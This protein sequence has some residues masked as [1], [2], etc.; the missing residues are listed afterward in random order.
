MK[1]LLTAF[2]A[3]LSVGLFS[4]QKEVTDIFN[5]SGSSSGTQLV[6]VISK[7]GSDSSAM[8]FGYNASKKLTDL[9]SFSVTSGTTSSF[10]MRA[11]RNAQGIIQKVII[12]SD[13]YQQY[14]LDSVITVV[15]YQAGHYSTEVTTID[16]GGMTVADSVY[17]TY[18]AGGRVIK[19]ESFFVA[20]GSADT[21]SKT[22]YTYN[23]N[24]I[25]TMKTYSYDPSTSSYTL[26]DTYTYDQYDDKQSPMYFGNDA[27]VFGS[28]LF[29]SYNNPL[30]SSESVLGTTQT[31]TITYTYNSANKPA[32]ASSIIQPGNTTATGTYYYQ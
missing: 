19:E 17:L 18:D 15:G 31:Y 23:G 11:V 24:N 6:K 1:N 9:N 28:P 25:A 7:S 14:G 27:F 26:I 21:M 5:N 29:D 30:K 2:L 20:L 13:Q 16:L 3:L 4:C 8:T 12:K 22:E 32:T 10:S